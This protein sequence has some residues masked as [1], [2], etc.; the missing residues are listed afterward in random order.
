MMIAVML[1]SMIG[2]VTADL[3]VTWERI[4]ETGATEALHSERC[5]LKE[6]PWRRSRSARHTFFRSCRQR[7]NVGKPGSFPC[8]AP[9]LYLTVVT[10]ETKMK[11]TEMFSGCLFK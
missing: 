6:Q 11:D 9:C 4:P 10:V 5:V 8:C 3:R 2:T 7:Y 1:L